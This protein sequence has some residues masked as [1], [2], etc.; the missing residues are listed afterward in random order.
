MLSTLAQEIQEIKAQLGRF[1]TDFAEKQELAG[2]L[3]NISQ[4]SCRI[5]EHAST[6]HMQDGDVEFDDGESQFLH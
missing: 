3:A 6:Q 1:V 5:C 4:G 2:G